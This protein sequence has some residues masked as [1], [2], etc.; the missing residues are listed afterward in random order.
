MELKRLSGCQIRKG[1]VPMFGNLVFILSV[2]AIE[3]F[4]R[5]T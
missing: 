4:I 5:V 3:V 2:V 1:L